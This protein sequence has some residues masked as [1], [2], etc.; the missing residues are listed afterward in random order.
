V[1]KSQTPIEALDDKELDKDPAPRKSTSAR[2]SRPSSAKAE[3]ELR[4]RLADCFD[5][6][7][8]VLEN[9][10]DDEL[11]SI[12]TEDA[13]VMAAGLVSMTR[14]FKVLRTPLLALVAVVEPLI[15]FGRIG[16]VLVGRLT[17]RRMANQAAYE[18]AQAEA[19]AAAAQ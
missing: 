1:A 9:R 3:N 4:T 14:P 18:Q 8:E 13:E 5:R 19:E 2:K 11:A 6:I 7:A 15:A 10:G 12:F 16:R 17:A